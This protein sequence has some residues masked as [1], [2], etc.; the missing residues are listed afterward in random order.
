MSI[1]PRLA[2][3]SPDCSTWNDDAL[4]RI[5]GE[6]AHQALALLQPGENASK[7]VL[8]RLRQ[9]RALQGLHHARIEL[10]SLAK[11]IVRALHHP[12][13][14]PFFAE[15]VLAL[16]EQEVVV[17]GRTAASSHHV[18]RMDRVVLFPD[19]TLWVLDFKLGSGD[20]SL[21]CE[22]VCGY[23]QLLSG[24]FQRPCHG[25]LIHLDTG[26]MQELPPMNLDPATVK[27]QSGDPSGANDAF[28][29]EGNTHPCPIQVFP[30]KANLLALLSKDLLRFYAP[31]QPL[32]LTAVQV[33]FPH[34]RPKI[35][36]LHTLVQAIN[37]PFLPPRCMSLE[38]WIL[39][40]ACLSL[41]APPAVASSLDQAWLLHGLQETGYEN[42]KEAPAWHQFLPWGL[43]LAQVMEELDSHQVR[44]RNL[45][46]PPDDLPLTARDMLARLGSLQAGFHAALE[47]ND[48]W[49]KASLARHIAPEQLRC[50]DP[51]YVCGLFALTRT[52]A[53][54]V[55]TLWRSGARLWWQADRPLP[56]QLDQ[57]VKTWRAR[58]EWMD[59]HSQKARFDQDRTPQKTF[60]VQAHDLH[61]QLRH[62]AANMSSWDPEEHIAVI[63]P[64][65][66]IL[67]PVLAHL[68]SAGQV[69][70]T[71]GMPLARTGLGA[72]LHIL[73]R[74]TR[75]RQ[76]SGIG[77]HPENLLF[78]LQSPWVRR[79]L[80]E[81]MMGWLR[82][83]LAEKGNVALVAEDLTWIS[84][85]AQER[86]T[87]MGHFLP[88]LAGLFF[89][90]L[91][92]ESLSSLCSYIKRLFRILRI[93]D[94]AHVPLE[95]HVA[96]A[97]YTRI[98][99]ELEHALCSSQNM[100]AGSLWSVFWTA[101]QAERI[102]FS[103][104]PLTPW[105]VMG[106]LESRLLCFDK[107]VVL[108]CVEGTLPTDQVPNP[109]LPEVLRPALGL[110]PG[111]ADEQI[112]RH[113][114]QR[115]I[116]S[117]RE[118]H[119]YSRQGLAADPLEGRKIPSR[120]WEQA[121]WKEEKHQGVRLEDSIIKV[122]LELDMSGKPVNVP[123][124]E[125]WMP[126]LRERLAAGLSLSALNTYLSC[127]IR[128]LYEQVAR[129]PS[130]TY[131]AHDPG[132]QVMGELAHKVLENL[133][134]PHRNACI[135][136][137]DLLP[138]LTRIWDD[139]VAEG[140][141][142]APLSPASRFFH[143]RLLHEL[144]SNYLRK[145]TDP[146]RPIMLEEPVQ[147]ALPGTACSIL[148]RGRLD[149]VDLDMETRLPLILDYKTGA[150]PLKR[151]LPVHH[152]WEL[153]E[154]LEN[155]PLDQ[156]SLIL[157]KEKLQDLQLPAYLF[158]LGR[159]ALSAFWLLGE[160][161]PK[162]AFVGFHMNDKKDIQGSLEDFL[163]WQ[164]Q[165]LPVLMEWLGRHI[166]ESARFTPACRPLSCGFCP[167][168]PVC[169]WTSG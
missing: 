78:F 103:G 146:V 73:V 115:L 29:P 92:L 100:P 52:E 110:P 6:L 128:F 114:F 153:S 25:A 167:W 97:L 27:P 90:A 163:T 79:L 46:S 83:T 160:W 36:L 38:D 50:H 135:V 94:T 101:L 61:S 2:L 71:L 102:P 117:P 75:D 12:K 41:D 125:Q 57:W 130:R 151:S 58:L 131:A 155:A 141:R 17:P 118:V 22:Q 148:L 111:H 158:L 86:F 165:G 37:A 42:E 7:D 144:L 159:P 19:K 106:L 109:L 28:F 112:I 164:R 47:A 82:Q 139:C 105:Q 162:R 39:H 60:L 70:I 154:T 156:E 48:L 59:D 104:E 74:T 32:N 31:G 107:V 35:H 16:A 91:D 44:G 14:A 85:Q 152:L 161:E 11:S 88:E 96:H 72:L 169:P 120:Y 21:D 142:D 140:L 147:R 18:L 77:P 45:D 10:E 134:R 20:P 121:L 5:Q 51:M 67:R 24:I 122:S 119:L 149:R 168:S 1:F 66:T 123:T 143:V 166:L 145:A 15:N 87:D 55:E 54:L 93:D 33:L 49:T 23:Q 137:R 40:Q 157:V 69:N 76:L 98:L 108:E 63:V 56:D 80:P 9:A 132:P 8:R 65:A 84:L 129:F 26:Q 138:Q 4:R 99:P 3:A 62:L 126:L 64:D 34:R 95:M 113:H 127:P 89:E 150:A 13:I 43:R 133:F 136:P 30:L 81:G 124:K 53:S 68:P 116:A